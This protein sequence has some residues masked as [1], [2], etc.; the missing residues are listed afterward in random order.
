MCKTS[1][2]TEPRRGDET[3]VGV[4]HSWNTGSLCRTCGQPEDPTLRNLLSKAK[5]LLPKSLIQGKKHLGLFLNKS[6]STVP[7]D[8]GPPKTEVFPPLC[9]PCPLIGVRA[10]LMTPPPPDLTVW[11]RSTTST[12]MAPRGFSNLFSQ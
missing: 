4:H 6:Q 2:V 7:L 9:S 1:E 5:A 10:P 8:L 3:A 12:R 11:S